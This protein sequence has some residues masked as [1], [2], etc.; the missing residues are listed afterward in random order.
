MKKE[1]ALQLKSKYPNVFRT[2]YVMPEEKQTPFHCIQAFGIEC[3]D[4]WYD[5]V[6]QLSAKVEAE[7]LKLP[8]EA[9]EHIFLNQ[10][11]SKFA[12]LRYYMSSGTDVI[13]NLISEAEQASF[14]ICEECGAPGEERVDSHWYFTQCD[15]CWTER[16]ERRAR[17]EAEWRASL[18][19]EEREKLVQ[20]EARWDLEEKIDAAKQVV[21]ELEEQLRD[22]LR[23]HACDA[24]GGKEYYT[25]GKIL[26]DECHKEE[27]KDDEQSA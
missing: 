15:K 11:K 6:D 10:V 5:L 23:C 12:G 19:P 9:R 22:L 2:M 17:E 7:I 18:T 4:G 8:E 16:E 26:C 27:K 14:R 24:P 13:W 21:I 1:L 25:L 3:G 20:R